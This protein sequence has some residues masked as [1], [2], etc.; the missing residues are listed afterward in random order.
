MEKLAELEE[1][2][3]KAVDCVNESKTEEGASLG[4][5]MEA[6]NAM[7]S[8]KLKVAAVQELQQKEEKTIMEH[9]I[10]RFNASQHNSSEVEAEGDGDNLGAASQ[11]L[12]Q[13]ELV[14]QLN[15]LNK[16]LAE[17]QQLAGTIGESD[18]KLAAMKKRYEEV[19]K[20]MEE[21]MGKPQREKDDLAQMQRND[22]AGAAKDIAERR[23]KKIQDLEEKIGEQQR[24]ANMASQNEA[25]AKKYQ[26]EIR[27]IKAA[28]VKLVKQMKEEADKVRV[29]KQSKEKEVIQLKQA[30]RKK[31]AAMSKMSVQHE[32]KQNVLKRRME[33]VL[34]INKRLKDAQ[35]KKASARAT[36][37]GAGTGLTGAGER[38]RGWVKTEMDVVVSAKEAEQA[39]QQL[40][41]ERKTLSEEMQKLKVESRRTMNSQEM[42]ET[43]SKQTDLQEQL[44]MRNL[45]ISELQKEIMLAEQD[46]E[47]SGDRWAKMTSMTDSKIAVS[48]LFNSATEA[49][50]TATTRAREVRELKSQMEELMANLGV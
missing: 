43:S 12:K 4:N 16:E 44:D 7:A 33:E 2:V 37:A 32:R 18:V 3:A 50:A 24:M 15:S 8:L 36:K 48:F 41:K 34:A 17:K 23:R 45:Q 10:T 38:V 42:E 49:M 46:K 11:T 21:E 29:W 5:N 30:D 22:G 31:A 20:T 47:K 6:K 39:R 1:S 27:V 40:I 9:D 25:K 26:E 35:A 19:L 14:T 13:N 28:K